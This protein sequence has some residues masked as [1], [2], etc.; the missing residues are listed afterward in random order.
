M[1]QFQNQGVKK[2]SRPEQEEI[3]HV[4]TDLPTCPYCGFE[5]E[6]HADMDDG[7]EISCENCG[8]L[9]K[10]EVVDALE[11]YT[12]EKIEGQEDAEGSD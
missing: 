9:F 2:M 1:K 8:K 3:V 5:H 7:E 4:E 12:T 11:S 10:L 6:E